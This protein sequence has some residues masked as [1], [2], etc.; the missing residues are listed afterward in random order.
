MSLE[1]WAR[2]DWLKPH[3]T[4]RQE[5]DGLLSIVARELADSQVEGVSADGRFNN[6]AT[7]TEVDELVA[8]A[9]E[10]SKTV[11]NWLRRQQR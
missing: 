4:S 3:E 2:N 11:Q 5:L 6:E 9:K 8:F 1:I 7:E 10:L